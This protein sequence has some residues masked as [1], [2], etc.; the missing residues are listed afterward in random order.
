M[1]RSHVFSLQVVEND[2]SQDALVAEMTLQDLLQSLKLMWTKITPIHN[3]H[4]HET[5]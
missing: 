4:P 1:E 2:C 3:E 5:E